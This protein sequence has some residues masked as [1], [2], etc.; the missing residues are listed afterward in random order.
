M[1]DKQSDSARPKIIQHVQFVSR[2]LLF[3]VYLYVG[4]YVLLM[5]AHMP[6]LDVRRAIRY[7]ST[8]RFAPA[9]YLPGPMTVMVYTVTPANYIFMPLDWV[10]HRFMKKDGWRDC[11]FRNRFVGQDGEG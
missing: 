7:E 11:D 6:C 8:C 5:T 10:T 9:Q 2:V 3:V 1:S 4:T